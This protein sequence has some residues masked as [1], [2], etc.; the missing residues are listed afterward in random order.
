[1]LTTK[2][3][4]VTPIVIPRGRNG[5]GMMLKPIRVYM[6]DSNN[7][8]MHH[9]IQSIDKDGPAWKAGLRSNTLVT[10]IN[11]EVSLI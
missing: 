2:K 8:R 6:G 3:M 5:Y 7:Y 9:I 4:S 10:H 11:G 1:L